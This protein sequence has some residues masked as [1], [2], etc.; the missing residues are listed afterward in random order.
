MQKK[1]NFFLVVIIL[2]L[3]VVF[4][5][6]TGK[7]DNEGPEIFFRESEIT[8]TEG[9]NDSVLLEDVTAVD[10]VSTKSKV[11]VSNKILTDDGKHMI[12]KYVA[13]DDAD[14]VTEKNR[15]VNYISK[16]TAEAAV[17]E[18][19]NGNG[20]DSAEDLIGDLIGDGGGN[21]TGEGAASENPSDLLGTSDTS[22]TSGAS[23][24]SGTSGTSDLDTSEHSG[25]V[26]GSYSDAKEV[27][28]NE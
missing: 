16:S 22:G 14:N 13:V 17:A 21:D 26:D 18:G 12:V 23:G 11:I 3:I 19:E 15:V 6:K 25:V 4:R 10:D 24:T 20:E 28:K 5:I 2:I 1:I 8:Y 9:D 27:D 7:K